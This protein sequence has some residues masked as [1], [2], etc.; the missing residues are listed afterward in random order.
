MVSA[1]LENR[2]AT[3]LEEKLMEIMLLHERVQECIKKHVK[4]S[5]R[6]TFP[7]D[8]L[9][10]WVDFTKILIEGFGEVYYE[11]FTPAHVLMSE[12]G[13]KGL[14]YFCDGPFTPAH[15]PTCK[16]LQIHVLEVI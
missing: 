6:F 7:I 11:P 4:G 16:K 14:C 13:S 15:V 2:T 9:L 12:R 8:S 10:V 3:R 5:E 1:R